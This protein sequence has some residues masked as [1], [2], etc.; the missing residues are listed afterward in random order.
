MHDLATT[1]KPAQADTDDEVAE[2]ATVDIRDSEPDPQEHNDPVERWRVPPPDLT[3]STVD[4]AQVALA[5]IHQRGAAEQAAAAHAAE[6]EPD[7][8]ARRAELA[9]WAEDDQAEEAS[10][11]H[12]NW[13]EDGAE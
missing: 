8:D 10:R 7:E 5:E 4:R 11:A 3:A 13:A 9:R 2:L 12:A 6:L 1:D